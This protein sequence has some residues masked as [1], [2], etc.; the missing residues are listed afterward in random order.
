[1]SN[2][3]DLYFW[4][5]QEDPDPVLDWDAYHDEGP[6]SEDL[7]MLQ[8][9]DEAEIEAWEKQNGKAS[10]LRR[11]NYEEHQRFFS[12]VLSYLGSVP[13][14]DHALALR[15]ALRKDEWDGWLLDDRAFPIFEKTWVVQDRLWREGV[16][17]VL[18]DGTP[19]RLVGD[20]RIRPRKYWDELGQFFADGT[21]YRQQAENYRDQALVHC[22]R[23]YV[24][25]YC[26][27]LD[28]DIS[29]DT[30]EHIEAWLEAGAGSRT[31]TASPC[32]AP[33]PVSSGSAQ[34]RPWYSPRG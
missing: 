25:D 17:V 9:F 8:V 20:A 14:A 34:W 28:I 31:C 1:M 33:I 26:R 16:R 4:R 3:N 22:V 18:R 6:E 11:D 13:V 10:S 21:L 23:R 30:T 7:E 12:G 29:F 5:R 15:C 19:R 2:S 24:E 27:G 32:S